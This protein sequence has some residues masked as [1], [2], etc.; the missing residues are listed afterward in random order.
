MK[1]IKSSDEK[2]F[3]KDLKSVY[4][5]PNIQEATRLL[6]EFRIK[7]DKYKVVLDDWLYSM[8]EW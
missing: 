5:A 7:W 6:E 2:D 1:F 3:L 8:D 4:N